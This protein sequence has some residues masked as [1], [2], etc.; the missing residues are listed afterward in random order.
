[1]DGDLFMECEEEELEPWQQM[2]DDVEEELEFI[3]GDNDNGEHAHWPTIAT[4]TD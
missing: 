1:M 3:E 2:Y 4:E